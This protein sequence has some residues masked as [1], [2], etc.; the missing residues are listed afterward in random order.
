MTCGPDDVAIDTIDHARNLIDALRATVIVFAQ[1]AL[2]NDRN[3][4]A[5]A[6]GPSRGFSRDSSGP[7]GDGAPGDDRVGSDV[8]GALE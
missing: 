7:R 5:S 3:M 2:E 1:R 8:E 4:A 6:A